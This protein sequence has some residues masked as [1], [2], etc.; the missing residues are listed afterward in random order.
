MSVEAKLATIAQTTTW[1]DLK[2][3]VQDMD[4]LLQDVKVDVIKEGR[5]FVRDVPA[6]LLDTKRQILLAGK[7]PKVF[8][9]IRA[10]AN[11][12]CLYNATSVALFGNESRSAEL[13]LAS[14]CHAVDHYDHYVDMYRG[15]LPTAG[16]AHQFLSQVVSA[17]S[18]FDNRPQ[19]KPTPDC[20]IHHMLLQE[21]LE[22]AKLGAYSGLLHF[23]FLSGAT[24]HQVVLHSQCATTTPCSSRVPAM[25][26]KKQFTSCG[27]A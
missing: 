22:A 27:L 16:D 8:Y 2:R 24:Q 5:T 21:I 13:R 14:V 12:N 25:N 11:G 20:I 19:D 18:I 9:A 1:A 15:M 23:Q 4:T 10:T 7:I 26:R 3:C 6:N 17:D